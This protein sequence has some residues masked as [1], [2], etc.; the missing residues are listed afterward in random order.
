MSTV[1]LELPHLVDL[2]ALMLHPEIREQ[3]KREKTILPPRFKKIMLS[4]YEHVHEV[5]KRGLPSCTSRNPH[6][7]RAGKRPVLDSQLCRVFYLF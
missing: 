1:F 3:V 5:E 6:T 4:I 2:V 7:F